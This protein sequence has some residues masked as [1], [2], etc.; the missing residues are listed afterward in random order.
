MHLLNLGQTLSMADLTAHTGSLAELLDGLR[1][2]IRETKPAP[3]AWVRGRGFNQDYFADVRRFPDRFDLDAVSRTHPICITRACGHICVVNSR[4]L[5]LLGIGRGTPQP[6]GGR[7]SVDDSGEP[8]GQFFENALDLVL[9]AMPAPDGDGLR[10]M[11]SAACRHL[12]R[13][14]ITSCQSD[15]YAVFP[16]L[17]YRPVMDALSQSVDGRGRHADRARQRTGALHESARP[18]GLCGIGRFQARDERFKNGPLKMLGDGSLGA[19]TA[20]LSRPYQDAPGTRG[21][22]VYT[23]AQLDAIVRLRQ[24]ARHAD[25][26][27]TPSATACSTACSTPAKRRSPCIRGATT[28]TASCTARS[29]GPT[30]SNASGRLGMHVYLQSIFLDYD[31]RIVFDRVGPRAGRYKLRGQIPAAK[32]RDVLERLRRAGE[33]PAVLRGVECA[34]TRRSIG[35]TA[36]PYRPEEA[37]SVREALDSF[38]Q[39]GAYASFEENCKGRI[40]AGMLADFVVLGENPFETAPDRLH[41]IDV[42]ATYLGGACVYRRENARF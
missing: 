23:Q 19:R 40:R 13:R 2:Y 31:A 5:E 10:A 29:P 8:L 30:S 33:D 28:A 17:G 11:L 7:F 41:A 36:P 1:S 35:S 18:A 15:D 38:T 21:L 9:K 34:V 27:S 12:N 4:A 37:L 6:A 25:R 24:R 20:Y 16:G 26:G 42:L 14:G 39:Y 3:G 32:R 22:P